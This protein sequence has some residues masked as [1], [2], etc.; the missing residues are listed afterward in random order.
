VIAQPDVLASLRLFAEE[1]MPAFADAK[2]AAPNGVGAGE[3]SAPG[4]AG[5][6]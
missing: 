6:R 1:V 5:G 3:P 2:A 4:G